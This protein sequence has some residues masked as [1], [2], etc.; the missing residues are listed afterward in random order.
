MKCSPEDIFQRLIRHPGDAPPQHEMERAQVEELVSSMGGH[1][2]ES[3]ISTD[4]G[5]TMTP[6]DQMLLA[7]PALLLLR[8]LNYTPS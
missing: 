3:P 4:E 2:V 8:T 7:L 6:E 1:G 5:P